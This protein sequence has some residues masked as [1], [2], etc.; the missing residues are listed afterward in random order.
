MSVDPADAADRFVHEGVTY[1]F[2]ASGCRRRFRG[3]PG[4][5][6]PVSEL[7]DVLSA[8]ENAVGD[9]VALAT[10]VA[11][12]GS[13]YR[14][15]GARLVIPAEGDTV[16]NISG[17]C[18]EGDVIQTAREVLAS[19]RPQVLHFDLTA[20]DEAV[21]GWG[22]GCNGAIDVLVEPAS[23]ARPFLAAMRAAR[24][25]HRQVALVTV[26]DGP[27]TGARMIAHPDG[28]SQG[29]LGS[30]ARNAA[31]EVL[32]SGPSATLTLEPEGTRAFIEVLEPPLRLVVCGAGHACRG[33]RRP[34]RL[35]RRGG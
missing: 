11:A 17:G 8:L 3:R 16:G 22:L 15:E 13:T 19:G 7:D 26:V 30:A 34:A 32:A 12:R 24:R 27:G 2:C 4:L 21:W 14:R 18:L 1:W 5:L 35:A 23:G 20:D 10:V 28:S 25:E 33:V 6:S 9:D 31:L 29:D